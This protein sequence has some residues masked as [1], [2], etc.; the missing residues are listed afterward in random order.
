[1]SQF[2]LAFWFFLQLAIYWNESSYKFSRPEDSALKPGL[3]Q[4]WS[5]WVDFFNWFSRCVPKKPASWWECRER[6]IIQHQQDHQQT[7][8]TVKD[9]TRGSLCIRSLETLCVQWYAIAWRGPS[10]KRRCAYPDLQFLII[11]LNLDC[12]ITLHDV[13]KSTNF[14]CLQ[15]YDAGKV[16]ESGT[17]YQCKDKRCCYT[18]QAR[19]GREKWS[20]NVK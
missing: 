8:Q 6:N 5:H 20:K 16:W 18:V 13:W 3:Q 1:M 7:G 12:S 14:P 4:Q 2:E 10:G 9:C 19:N 15:T 11:P 17:S